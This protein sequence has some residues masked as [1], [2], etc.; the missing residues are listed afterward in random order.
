MAPHQKSY[1]AGHNTTPDLYCKKNIQ[2]IIWFHFEQSD[3]RP[4]ITHT[5]FFF[6]LVQL[7]RV[8]IW[9]LCGF[10][11]RHFSPRINFQLSVL[12]LHLLLSHSSRLHRITQSKYIYISVS[13]ASIIPSFYCNR[14]VWLIRLFLPIIC[15]EKMKCKQLPYLEVLEIK[16]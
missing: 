4:L 13:W 14:R 7:I 2:R 3:L 6:D 10:G 1:T 5:C 11:I 12:A 9:G 15:V 8:L 16:D